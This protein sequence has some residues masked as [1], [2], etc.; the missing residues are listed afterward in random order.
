MRTLWVWRVLFFC[1]LVGAVVCG[2][3]GWQGSEEM[4]GGLEVSIS[5]CRFTLIGG[6]FYQVYCIHSVK[7]TNG[8]NR[9]IARIQ[10]AMFYK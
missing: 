7:I 6:L 4:D 5:R 10:F 2:S 9:R 3:G 1:E 8:T